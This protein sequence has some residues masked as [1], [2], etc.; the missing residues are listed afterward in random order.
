[1]AT[2]VP[3][4]TD[5]QVKQ[6]IIPAIQQH[7]AVKITCFSLLCFFST[8]MLQAQQLAF[9]TAEGSGRFA[10][11][12]RGGEMYEVTNLNNSGSGS[13]VDAVSKGNRTRAVQFF[14][15]R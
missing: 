9:P 4:K 12:G 11:G 14:Q 8:A 1:M 5:L 6:R 3:Q 13:I 10:A 15:F 7:V 2:E